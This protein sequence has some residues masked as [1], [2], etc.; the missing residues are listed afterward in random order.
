MY[1]IYLKASNVNENKAC[2]E[3]SAEYGTMVKI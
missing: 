3:R 1:I 2:G